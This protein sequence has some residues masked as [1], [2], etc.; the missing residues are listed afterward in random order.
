MC[1]KGLG[2]AAA[3]AVLEDACHHRLLQLGI[4][5][6]EQ[7]SLGISEIDGVDTAVGVVLLRE[8]KE[9]AI[10]VLEEFVRSHHVPV[11]GTQDFGILLAACC[12]AVVIDL[13]VECAASCHDARIAALQVAEGLEDGHLASVSPVALVALVHVLDVLHLIVA[14]HG[15]AAG[16]L[17]LPEVVDV[18]HCGHVGNLLCSD[19][20][21]PCEALASLH[22]RAVWAGKFACLHECVLHLIGLPHAHMAVDGWHVE[23]SPVDAD[24]VALLGQYGLLHG[25]CL[26]VGDT[27]LEAAA[28]E[29]GLVVLVDSLLGIGREVE[30]HIVLLSV[31]AANLIGN[32]VDGS[33][34]E[35][36][37]V[38]E[39]GCGE[40]QVQLHRAAHHSI[41]GVGGQYVHALLHGGL[42][43]HVLWLHVAIES[44]VGIGTSCGVVAMGGYHVLACMEMLLEVGIKVQHHVVHPGLA[45]GCH[46][47]SVDIE[48]EHIVVGILQIE[49][50]SQLLGTEFHLSA[51][52]DIASLTAPLIA[53][54]IQ[55]IAS[56]GSL[57]LL[58]SG[59]AGAFGGPS[60]SLH[61]MGD[62]AFPALLIGHGG[63]ALEHILLRATHKAIGGAIHSEE[64]QNGLLGI[65]PVACGAV[66]EPVVGRPH[67][68]VRVIDHQW[69]RG[70]TQ[71][72]TLVRL[73]NLTR[74]CH[75][76]CCYSQ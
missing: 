4:I 19:A 17:H 24:A 53:H 27:I 54:I 48:L 49:V 12:H 25:A 9:V 63:Y 60:I 35:V 38:Y 40:H 69:H 14:Q 44:E 15:E 42:Q 50:G 75:S 72:C 29:R 23:V 73:E 52:I 37:V 76:C 5:D 70:Q 1:R 21:A 55:A 41:I 28:G 43:F 20:L 61:L 47:L 65:G 10:L 26:H 6:E 59:H 31:G 32:I 51:D 45:C 71:V 22:L 33:G 67:R 64:S 62:K 56:P 8:P 66:G 16:L 30:L 57:L 68:K 2:P 7:W 3:S 74:L 18:G 58:P 34:D 46:L 36:I 39:H 11:R 13:A